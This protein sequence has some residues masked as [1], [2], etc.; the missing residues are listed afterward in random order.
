MAFGRFSEVVLNL[1]FITPSQI[2]PAVA[3]GRN[4]EL[5]VQLKV[6]ELLLSHDVAG[7]HLV[8]QKPVCHFP[9]IWQ[10]RVFQLPSGHILAAKQ[11]DRGPPLGMRR[12]GQRRSSHSEPA[13]SAPVF[14]RSR[15]PQLSL[16]CVE[17]ALEYQVGL[18][19]FVLWRKRE[20]QLVGAKIDLLDGPRA[21]HASDKPA[22]Q[23]S[24]L[25]GD[26]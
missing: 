13:E 19:V 23:F 15:T 26:L 5:Q 6:L 18:H 1:N 7:G 9:P 3:L 2:N 16:A 24:F 17:A 10:L 8:F 25:P 12:F 22:R 14:S 20:F 11:C 21:P 4:I